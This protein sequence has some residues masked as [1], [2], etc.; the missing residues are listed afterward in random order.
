MSTYLNLSIL[1]TQV[2]K[3]RETA[4][5]K[6]KR[7]ERIMEKIVGDMTKHAQNAHSQ[8]G[9]LELTMNKIL[10]AIEYNSK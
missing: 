5:S 3:E 10:A 8:A 6:C 9:N 1:V 2:E 7:L 4:K